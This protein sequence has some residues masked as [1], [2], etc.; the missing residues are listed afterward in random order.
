M[1]RQFLL[2][3]ILT[4]SALMQAE[5]FP[6]HQP[7]KEIQDVLN[8]PPIPQISV[9]PRHD[10]AILMQAVRYPPITELAQPML[11]LAGIRIDTNT[12]GLHMAPYFVSFAIKRLGDG[13]DVA[14]TTR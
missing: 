5:D 8:A 2:A 11:R 10:Y 1:V 14:I 4:A 12:N 13:G 6:Y 7:P 9:S 3:S